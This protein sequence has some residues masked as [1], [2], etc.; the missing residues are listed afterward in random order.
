[1]KTPLL[2][3]VLGLSTAALFALS[4]SIGAAPIPPLA[5][6]LALVGYGDP[7]DVLI[8]RELRLP[9]AL[10]GAL[11]GATLALCGAALQGLVRNPL[12]APSVFGAPSAAAFGAVAAIA[13]G[14]ADVLSY[15]LPVAAMLGALLS[16]G[17]L[18]LLAGPSASMLTLILSGLALS[19]LAS[20]AVSLALNLAPN[21]FSALE[22][23]FWLLGSLEDRSFQHV[24]MAAPFLAACW[25]ILLATRAPLRA[26]TLGEEVART[27]GVDLG[28][29]R[30]AVVFGVA[31]GVGGGVAVAG[32][33]GFVGLMTPHVVRPFVGHDPARVHLPAMLAGA[34]LVLAADCAARLIPSTGEIRIGVLTSLIGA[35]FF[36]WLVWRE[37]GRDLV[38]RG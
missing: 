12:A 21:P 8:V 1:M 17:A 26:L 34:A 11:I 3:I 30:L 16:V 4:L 15:A 35:P 10:L 2:F 19:S 24:A 20:A 22:I 32:V 23:A 28:R 38:A 18:L 27:S 37:R 31:C 9:R 36:I 33:I 7:V 25:L 14:A 13:M 6:A 5:A 29:L